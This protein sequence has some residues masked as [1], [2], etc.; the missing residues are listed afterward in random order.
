MLKISGDLFPSSCLC[1]LAF[2]IAFRET[3]ERITLWKQFEKDLDDVFG[4]LCEVPF[5]KE[6]PAHVQLD[7]LAATWS[8]HMTADQVEAT[9]VDEAVIYAVCET[10]ARVVEQDPVSVTRYLKGGPLDA[11]VPVDHHLASE[12]RNLHLRLKNDGDFLLISQ[13]LDIE[14]V[15]CRRLKK[16]FGMAIEKTDPLFDVL[17]RWTM[18]AGFPHNLRG[19]L[20][21]R[22]AA[23]LPA[24]LGVNCPAV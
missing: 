2:R 12:I 3:Q 13:F 22:E 1:Y 8:K 5:L 16:Q 14:P 9:L 15:E 18:S 19:L 23:R 7:L 20:T 17:G 24:I 10:A 4:F 21:D 6:V 11:L